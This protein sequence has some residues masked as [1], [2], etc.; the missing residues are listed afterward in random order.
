VPG[1]DRPNNTPFGNLGPN[2]CEA[3]GG[4]EEII[5]PQLSSSLAPSMP[6]TSPKVTWSGAPSETRRLALARAHRRIAAAPPWARTQ[7]EEEPTEAGA[8][9]KEPALPMA[10]CQAPADGLVERRYRRCFRETASSRIL[11]RGARLTTARVASFQHLGVPRIGGKSRPWHCFVLNGLDEVAVKRSSCV[12]RW[13]DSAVEK[14]V[15]IAITTMPR[16]RKAQHCAKRL[17]TLRSS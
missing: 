11:V 17:F 7:Q 10:C 9:G 5:R 1:E 2:S 16:A 15:P 6:A 4:L 12:G 14:A 13:P 3:I 8:A